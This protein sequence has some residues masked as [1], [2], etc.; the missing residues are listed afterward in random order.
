MVFRDE[1]ARA[2]NEM[3]EDCERFGSEFD[4]ARTIRIVDRAR[5]RKS[6]GPV[7]R[8]DRPARD[9][10]AFLSGLANV[11]D[12][13]IGTVMSGLSRAR[14]ALRKSLEMEFTQ[15]DKEGGAQ[16]AAREPV[17]VAVSGRARRRE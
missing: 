12:I 14:N 10:R 7:P 13:P 3:F 6:A 11:L 15:S 5:A 4:D 1:F 2:G 9:G 17:S 16:G 8:T